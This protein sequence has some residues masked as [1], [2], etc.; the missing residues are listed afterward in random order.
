MSTDQYLPHESHEKKWP[1]S[2][3]LTAIVVVG[4]CVLSP[5]VGVPVAFFVSVRNWNVNRRLAIVMLVVAVI[6]SLLLLSLVG[7][8]VS[9]GSVSGPHLA[10]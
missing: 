8:A 2:S 10:P 4:L 9:G 1:P 3:L 7:P 6:W 5:L